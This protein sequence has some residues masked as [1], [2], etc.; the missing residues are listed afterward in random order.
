M[1]YQR[2]DQLYE[3]FDCSKYV[4]C[5]HGDRTRTLPTFLSF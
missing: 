3:T 4:H 5:R 1:L 2:L